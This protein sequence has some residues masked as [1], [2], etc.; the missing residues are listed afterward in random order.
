[1]YDQT[2]ALRGE[3]AFEGALALREAEPHAVAPRAAPG[4]GAQ[5]DILGPGGLPDAGGDYEYVPLI[6]T[7]PSENRI[8]VWFVGDGYTADDRD[9]LLADVQAQM[10]YLFG[11]AL[12]DPFGRYQDAFNVHVVVAESA[13]R[14]ADRPEDGVYVDTAFDA[15][16]SWNGGVERCLYLDTGLADAAVSAVRPDGV[17][18]DMRFG[19]VN[20][21]IYG[22]CGG[23]WAVYSAGVGSAGDLALHEVAH[24]YVGLADEYWTD[25]D[26]HGGGEPWEVNVTADA[27]GAKWGRW[28]GY[29]DGVLGPIGAYEGGL[30]VEDG[31]FRPTENSKMRTLGQPFDAV[32]KEAFVLAFYQDVDPLDGWAFEGAGAGGLTDEYAFWVDPFSSGVIDQRWFLDGVEIDGAT[33][34]SLSLGTLGLAPGSYTLTAQAYDDT[35]LVRLDTDLLSQ[36]VTWEVTTRYWA[37]DGTGA[38]DA[39]DGRA[40]ADRLDGRG[41]DD[42][43]EGLGG[44]DWLIGGGGADLV[45][46]GAGADVIYGDGVV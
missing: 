4:G 7:G 28:L 2:E 32:A 13:E 17:D 37:F 44:D 29:D 33:G 36:T 16:Y 43:L 23:S 42:T 3:R 41:G 31:I 39:M 45:L 46:G 26:V 1:M 21:D 25:G 12:A 20:S 15:S 19:V 34:E 18:V 8:D 10:A 6:V 30:Y 27:S 5:P 11:D 9:Q 40:A 24:A 14:G 38:G 22:G 35:G